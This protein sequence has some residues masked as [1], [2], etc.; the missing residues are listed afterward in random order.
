MNPLAGILNEAWSMYKAHAWHLIVIALV[1]YVAAAI[2]VALLALA[3][4]IGVLLGTV[5]ELFAGF[6]VQAAL[7]KAVQDVRDGR[8]DL[9]PGETVSAAMPS[10]WPVAGASI[11]AGIAIA[12]GLFLLLVPGLFLITIWA[13]IIPVIVI[14][15]S[16]ALASFARSQAIVRGHGWHVFG[17]LVLVWIIELLVGLILQLI[18]AALPVALSSGLS[19]VISGALISPFIALVVTLIYYRLTGR[20]PEARVSPGG[21][22]VA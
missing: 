2:V 4:L 11:L 22:G 3:G 20:D 12:V 7:V 14:E 6:L 17:T 13:V 1:I 15:R 9:S 16:G 21:Y 5:V 18:F 10:I 19:S 8:A